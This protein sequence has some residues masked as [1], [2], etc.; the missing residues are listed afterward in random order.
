MNLHGL[1]LFR[2]IAQTRSISRAAALNGI[3]QS[4]ASQAVQEVERTLKLTLL[5]RSRR[6]LEVTP[7]GDLYFLFCRDVLLRF[8]GFEA[9]IE[10]LKNEIAG[11]V[12]VASIYSV[13]ITEMSRLEAQFSRRYPNGKLEVEYLRPDRLRQYILDDLADIGLIS[14]PEASK[15][16]QMI[17]WRDEEM[18][19]ACGLTH[20]LCG[21]DRV[22]PSDL[23]SLDFVAFDEDLPIRHVIDAYLNENKTG[24]RVKYHFDNIQSI[25]EAVIFGKGV[26]IL[27]KAILQQEVA[28]GR[29]RVIPLTV[30]L[31]RPLGI[32]HHKRKHFSPIA[33]AFLNLLRES[34][35]PAG[36]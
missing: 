4:A 8:E 21:M 7:A 35:V 28:E 25:K 31:V 14:Y 9:D 30:A 36:A 20:P 19:V 17:P 5:D 24:V 13:G 11:T 34:R 2:D 6:P 1:R 16:I 29:L 18:V 3:T 10:A 26:S 23:E 33:L 15:E 27:P 12:R 22:A 32:I